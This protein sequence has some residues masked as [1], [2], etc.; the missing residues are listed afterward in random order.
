M[1]NKTFKRLKDVL[2]SGDIRLPVLCP[3]A[4]QVICASATFE[5]LTFKLLDIIRARY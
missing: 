3:L 1:N 5:P 2:Q 4:Q